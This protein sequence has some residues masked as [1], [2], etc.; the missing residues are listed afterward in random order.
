[1]RKFRI[2]SEHSIDRLQLG[3]GDELLMMECG[4]AD[5]P[6]AKLLQVSSSA[7]S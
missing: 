2:S 6:A 1:M 7:C 3:R 5:L 4:K